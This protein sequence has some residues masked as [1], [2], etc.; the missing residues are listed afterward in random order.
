[1]PDAVVNAEQISADKSVKTL[2]PHETHIL[3]EGRQQTKS[4]SKLSTMLQGGR[5][6]EK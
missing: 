3:V 4:S 5:Y 6:G 1:M 2:W